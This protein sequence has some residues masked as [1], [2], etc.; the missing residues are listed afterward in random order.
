[1]NKN[2]VIAVVILFILLFVLIGCFES[3]KEDS[4]DY[5]SEYLEFL[6]EYHNETKNYIDNITK[7]KDEGNT[8]MIVYW[9]EKA[10]SDLYSNISKLLDFKISDDLAFCRN[11]SIKG[12]NCLFDGCRD[13]I[14]GY[15]GNF[16]D[17]NSNYFVS[18]Q[19]N[20][21]KFEYYNYI[22]SYC[23]SNR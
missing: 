6:E 23:Y 3:T 16:T 13:L 4:I 18:A 9:C 17:E 14:K 15:T 2:L 12:Y 10:I 20:F 19:E 8:A 5:D 22:A 1:M 21:D 7:Y 11:Y